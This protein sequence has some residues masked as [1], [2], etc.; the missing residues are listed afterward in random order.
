MFLLYTIL[1]FGN[2]VVLS[3][4]GDVLSSSRLYFRNRGL[5]EINAKLFPMYIFGKT[6]P[7]A[8]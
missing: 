6:Y 2:Y 1:E 5:R 4:S 7:N 8:I 3:G